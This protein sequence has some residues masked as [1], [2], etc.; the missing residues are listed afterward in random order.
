M[1]SLVGDPHRP[2]CADVIFKSYQVSNDSAAILLVSRGPISGNRLVPANTI[3]LE[4]TSYE[5]EVQ[6]PCLA[7]QLAQCRPAPKTLL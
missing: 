4:P 7:P 3:T 5:G 2:S 6:L 1:G